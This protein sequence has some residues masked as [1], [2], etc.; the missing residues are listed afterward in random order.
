MGASMLAAMDAFSPIKRLRA[1]SVDGPVAVEEVELT[2]TPRPADEWAEV[3]EEDATSMTRG[4]GD[5]CF[6]VTSVAAAVEAE[7]EEEEEVVTP[8]AIFEK[9]TGGESRVRGPPT[10]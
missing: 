7:E 6:I 8:A 1:D 9:D 10:P 4:R 2:I 3:E 5:G